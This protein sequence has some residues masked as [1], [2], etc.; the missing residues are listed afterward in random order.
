M[1]RSFEVRKA[2]MMKT[3]LQK[4]RLY[5]RFGREIYVCARQGGA[6]VEANL[7]LKHLIDRAKK[8]QVPNDIIKRNIEKAQGGTGEDFVSVRYE[9][10]GPGGSAVLVDA[11]TDNLNR[12]VS[13]VRACFTKVGSKLG[14][15]GSVEHMYQHLAL[16]SVRGVDSETVLEALLTEDIDIIDIEETEGVVE[17]TGDGYDLDK[18]Q[19]VLDTVDGLE[20]LDSEQGWFASESLTLD[21]E[22]KALFEKLVTMLDQCED[23]QN[24]FHNV[25]L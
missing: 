14:V 17:V 18:I 7:A 4:T 11:L 22:N 10:F 25:E 2:A 23:V 9:G 12:T 13:E 15:K 24:V 16:V 5:S 20:I 19:G 1:G 21:E 6:N 3:G 8:Q